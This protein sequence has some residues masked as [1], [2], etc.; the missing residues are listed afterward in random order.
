MSEFSE[1]HSVSQLLGAPPGYIGYGDEGLLTG[2]LRSFPFSVVLLDEIDRA[3]PHILDVLLQ[4]FDEGRLT[5]AKGYTVDA[6]NV[7]FIMTTNIGAEL[8]LQ[9]N[10]NGIGFSISKDPVGPQEKI[11]ALLRKTFSLEFI[12]RIDEIVIFN[13]LTHDD[14][15]AITRNLLKDYVE[16]VRNQHGLQMQID[17]DSVEILGKKGYSKLYGLRPMKKAINEHISV[18]LSTLLLQDDTMSEPTQIYVTARDGD[19]FVERGSRI[20][21]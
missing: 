16:M 20:N 11:N 19:I 14:V 9:E 8:I 21:K 12:N 13:Q 1:K 2:K 17:E 18:P 3:H 4:L 15:T 5:D 7:I 6:K 10:R